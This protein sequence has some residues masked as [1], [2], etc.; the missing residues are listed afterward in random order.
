[1]ST[2]QHEITQLDVRSLSVMRLCFG[3][4]YVF[5]NLERLPW[6]AAHYSDNG[7]W[8][9]SKIVTGG[10]L[11][12]PWT[13]VSPHLLSGDWHIQ[14]TLFVISAFLGLL[15]LL[16]WRTKWVTPICW[17]L[18]CSAQVRN[19]LITNAGDAAFRLV[20]FWS[21]FLPWGNRFS[22]DSR[23]E[24]KGPGTIQSW[25]G[26]GY[27]IQMT[28]I[29]FFAGWNKT[30][31]EWTRDGNAAYLVLSHDLFTT[32]FGHDLLRFP[33]LLQVSTYGIVWFE[34]L[35]AL[36]L[37]SPFRMSLVRSIGITLATILHLCLGLSM[38]FGAITWIFIAALIGLFPSDAWKVMPKSSSDFRRFQSAFRFDA[39]QNSYMFTFVPVL[40]IGSILTY[41]FV[42]PPSVIRGPFVLAGNW[43]YLNQ[44]WAMYAPSPTNRNGWFVFPG[45][46]NSGQK[47]DL[48]RGGTSLS[49]EKPKD[50]S[51]VYRGD[52]WLN[53]FEYTVYWNGE[54][55][56]EKYYPGLAN[57][58]C[59]SWNE[60]HDGQDRL[61]SLE[62]VYVL[63]PT[64]SGLQ[65]SKKELLHLWK[66]NC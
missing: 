5:T 15:L 32:S 1:M 47:V 28:A 26:V 9:R 8:P 30:G 27:L 29:Y 51:P 33:R 34:R 22:L 44:S 37:W 54:K 39:L 10:L 62:L 48:F 55:Q 4:I 35:M 31:A 19:P 7:I 14:F 6:V 46:L 42:P 60:N 36:L 58:I 61:S 23:R 24:I 13:V 64:S 18:E 40:L 11:T 12:N 45:T 43:A 16:G 63:T 38:H 41:N 20:L 21:M 56:P 53:Y 3:T 2:N 66:Q 17:F 52:S 57:Y 25:W 65:P 49:W 50:L 59:R